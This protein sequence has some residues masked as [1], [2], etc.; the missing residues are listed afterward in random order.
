MQYPYT[1]PTESVEFVEFQFDRYRAPKPSHRALDK[2]IDF[3]LSSV[4]KMRHFPTTPNDAYIRYNNPGLTELEK[5]QIL[6]KLEYELRIFFKIPASEIDFNQL[7]LATWA[8]IM[9]AWSEPGERIVSWYKKVTEEKNV[10]A[11]IASG[12]QRFG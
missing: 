3:V 12:N 4:V 5:H 10:Q 6:G 11:N 1:V 7:H 2:V 9:F 8:T